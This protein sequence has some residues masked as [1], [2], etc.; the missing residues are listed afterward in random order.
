MGTNKREI[1]YRLLIEEALLRLLPPN[2]PKYEKIN[3]SVKRGWAGYRGELE[4]DYHLNFLSADFYILRGLRL[5]YDNLYFQIDTLLLCPHFFLIIESKNYQGTLSFQHKTTR[6]INTK[7]E[8]V[9]NP[10]LQAKR[11]QFLLQ[12][13]LVSQ[14]VKVPPIL[15]LIA[16]S[17]PTTLIV[18]DTE[19]HDQVVH[20]EQVP[21]KIDQLIAAHPDT[22]PSND[23]VLKVYNLLYD[24]A[25]HT[26]FDAL[27]FYDVTSSEFLS[28]LLCPKCPPTK[29]NR[30]HGCW[31]CPG[32]HMISKKAYVSKVFD[33]LL[34]CKSINSQQCKSLLGL[35]SR[36]TARRL[37][38]GLDLDRDDTAK[39]QIYRLNES[40]PPS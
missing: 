25:L 9:N 40:F 8:G 24:H 1:P 38:Q 14:K 33:Y 15:N 35:D 19:I 34:L 30:K 16:I 2:H 4:L 22:S 17:N 3:D 36:H 39:T 13:W 23:T 12:K 37:L 32:C 28:G 29:L 5:A 26:Y 7:H 18:G 10:L 31:F 21:S 20:A 6:T 11:Q 27:S